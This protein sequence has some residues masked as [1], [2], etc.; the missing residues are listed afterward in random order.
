MIAGEAPPDPL[1]PLGVDAVTLRTRDHPAWR[2]SMD[3]IAVGFCD[4]WLDERLHEIG[5]LEPWI[6]RAVC[7]PTL[8][9][10]GDLAGRALLVIGDLHGDLGAMSRLVAL[11][12]NPRVLVALGLLEPNERRPAIALLGDLIDRGPA[13][14]ACAAMALQIR[15]ALPEHSILLA[16]NHESAVAEE[17]VRGR[18]RSDVEPAEFIVWANEPLD[19]RTPSSRNR[20]SLVRCIACL[21]RHGARAAMIGTEWLLMHGGVPHEDL[22]PRIETLQSL[23]RCQ[24]VRDDFAWIRLHPTARRKVPNR[25]RRG[26]EI[27]CVQFGA[28]VEHLRRL[29]DPGATDGLPWTAV[30]GHDHP[31]SGVRVQHASHGGQA[32]FTLH[33]MRLEDD[34]AHAVLLRAGRSPVVLRCGD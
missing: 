2:E 22:L 14:A 10:R 23:Q 18:F 26:C 19:P 1:R 34:F 33:S 30:R 20:G 21:G 16:G 4:S 13:S 12:R 25:T 7:A 6:K 32:I 31:E 27:G 29:A 3:A 24:A 17:A 5:S 8:A 11:W 15:L 28:G 9:V